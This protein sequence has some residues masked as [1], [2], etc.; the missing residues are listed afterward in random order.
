MQDSEHGKKSTLDIGAAGF[1]AALN[2][3]DKWGCSNEQQQAILSLPKSTFFKYKKNPDNVR[4]DGDHLERLSY[5]LNIH[6]Y[7]RI[8]FDNPK[9]VYGFMGMKNN[10]IF[11]NGRS[12]L[13]II[14]SGKFSA[15]YE[16]FK[17]I[18]AMR[19]GHW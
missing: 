2:I 11:F 13:D 4:L 9:N 7:L 15:L 1:K 12:P 3:L 17:R 10:N 14:S 18:D 5:L 19:G 8:I 6:A 16:T